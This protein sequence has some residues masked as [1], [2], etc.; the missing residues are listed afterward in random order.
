MG[1]VSARLLPE[2][3]KFGARFFFARENAALR[4]AQTDRRQKA[5]F[6]SKTRNETNFKA[7]AGQMHQTL[8]QIDG[9]PIQGDANELLS[10]HSNSGEMSRWSLES[11]APARD[12]LTGLAVQAHTPESEMF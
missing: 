8:D 1:A 4:A 12:F 10:V 7:V 9:S 2:S 6:N 5:F 3:E 11:F